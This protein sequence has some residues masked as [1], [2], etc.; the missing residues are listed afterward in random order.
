MTKQIV[1]LFAAFTAAMVLFF[2]TSPATAQP[3]D[4]TLKDVAGTG[5]APPDASVAA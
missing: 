3:S 1:C 5:G 4:P 2:N